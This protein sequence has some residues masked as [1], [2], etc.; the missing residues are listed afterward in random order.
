[1]SYNPIIN[2]YTRAVEMNFNKSTYLVRRKSIKSNNTLD[3]ND[4]FLVPSKIS[5]AIINIGDDQFVLTHIDKVFNLLEVLLCKFIVIIFEGFITID[6]LAKLFRAVNNYNLHEVTLLLNYSDELYS[7]DFAEVVLSSNR[8][9]SIIIFNSPFDKNLENTIF[10]Y[11]SQRNTNTYN[12]SGFEFIPRRELYAESL[13][14]HSY[15]NKKLFIDARGEIK[16]SP[17]SS[18]TFG[19]I[20]DY[21]STEDLIEVINSKGFQKYWDVKKDKCDICK[22]CEYRYMC[23]DNRLPY[24]RGNGEWYHKIECNYNPY[25]AK[26]EGEKG[27]KSL[28]DCKVVSNE[29]GFSMNREKIESINKEL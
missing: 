4:K 17:E 23:V 19:L 18:K 16:N 21:K 14:Y 25:I 13:N 24:Y 12:K 27:Y 1:M 15:F 2:G 11:K 6:D 5:N 28:K 9:K 3:K 10:Y 20:M 29:E 22:D 7:D 8:F 26:W